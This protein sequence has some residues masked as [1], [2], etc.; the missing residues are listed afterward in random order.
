MNNDPKQLTFVCT[1]Q[2]Y[3]KMGEFMRLAEN[4][5]IEGFFRMADRERELLEAENNFAVT[6]CA[7]LMARDKADI[8]D[9][10]INMPGIDISDTNGI[11][12]HLAGQLIMAKKCRSAV[13]CF[14]GNA[15]GD[16][17]NIYIYYHVLAADD[18]ELFE[19]LYTEHSPY[20]RDL[21]LL[22]AGLFKSK[23]ILDLI[24]DNGKDIINAQLPDDI[25]MLRLVGRD[26]LVSYY[27]NPFD[28]H[29]CKEMTDMVLLWIDNICRI[30]FDSKYSEA[31]YRAAKSAGLFDVHFGISSVSVNIVLIEATVIKKCGMKKDDLTSFIDLCTND[32]GIKLVADIAG[33]SPFIVID[34]FSCTLNWDNVKKLSKALGTGITVKLVKNFWD[35]KCWDDDLK[36]EIDMENEE[37]V[38]YLT[39]F[40]SKEKPF[41]ANSAAES[42]K[43]KKDM[44]D[45]LIDGGYATE[46]QITDIIAASNNPA[47]LKKLYDKTAGKRKKCK[48][49]E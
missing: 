38:G 41:F 48:K 13:K 14:I 21:S 39:E 34:Y 11:L 28:S 45:M 18:A 23:R 49:G 24:T 32:D 7:G 31:V 2:M 5:D 1:G 46:E 6:L 35:Y 4:D 3:D 29:Y 26:P 27:G 36:P 43:R 40:F 47:L 37:T 19:L 22:T 12:A 20:Y 25:D 30:Y 42:L 10:F 44:L 16:I 15:E 8:L 33:K 9:R 17:A